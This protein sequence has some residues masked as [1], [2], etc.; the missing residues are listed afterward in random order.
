MNF[1]RFEGACVYKGQLHALTEVII[2]LLFI[3]FLAHTQTNFLF[4]GLI[5][6]GGGHY[7]Y[8]VLII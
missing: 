5:F 7:L 6:M 1:A 8:L 3:V 4:I 2:Q